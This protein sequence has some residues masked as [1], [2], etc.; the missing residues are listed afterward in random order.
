MSRKAATPSVMLLASTTPIR[1]NEGEASR[2][3]PYLDHVFM[4]MM[5]NH[6]DSQIVGN[7]NVPFANQYANSANSTTNY[8]AVG[9][10]GSTNYLEIVGGSNFGG[11]SDNAPDWHNQNCTPNLGPPPYTTTDFPSSANV[12]PIAGVGTDAA[13]PASDLS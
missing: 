2:G 4:I 10:P 11:R 9:H 5:E 1:A 3:V 6:G 7:P 13:T 8:F 12:C